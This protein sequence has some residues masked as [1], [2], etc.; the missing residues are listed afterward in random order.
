MIQSHSIDAKLK[1]TSYQ[2]LKIGS[3]NDT[4]T[5]KYFKEDQI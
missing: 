5:S 2:N 3:R 1:D 4:F